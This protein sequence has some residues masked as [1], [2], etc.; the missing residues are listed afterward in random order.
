MATKHGKAVAKQRKFAAKRTELGARKTKLAAKQGKRP[1]R[2]GAQPR[3]GRRTTLRVPDELETELSKVA[4]ELGVRENEALVHLA[5]LGARAAKRERAVRRV[6]GKRRAAV[7]GSRAGAPPEVFPSPQEM[8][9]AI[10]VD[11]D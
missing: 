6:I 10:L 3:L 9:E 1:A 5:A 2:A 7:S 11:R 4:A 8:Q